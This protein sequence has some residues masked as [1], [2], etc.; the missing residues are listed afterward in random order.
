MV[1]KF[2]LKATIFLII[3]IFSEKINSIGDN[4]F[5]KFFFTMYSSN[6]SQTPY[7]L[8]AYSPSEHLKI[9]FSK[10]TN[11]NIITKESTS[12]YA[13]ANFSSISYYDNEYIIKTCFGKNKII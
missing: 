9:D 3:F 11:E 6:N 7:I 4:N 2:T 10:K 1:D 13:N 12:D 5:K 8:N